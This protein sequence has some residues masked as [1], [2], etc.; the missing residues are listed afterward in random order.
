V[1]LPKQIV[2]PDF[3]DQKK[4]VDSVNRALFGIYN[5]LLS[6]EPD[7]RNQVLTIAGTFQPNGGVNPS[8]VGE[9]LGEWSVTRTGAGFY[10]IKVLDSEAKFLGRSALISKTLTVQSANTGD[11]HA[12]F[13][14]ISSNLDA[15]TIFVDVAGVGVDLIIGVNETISFELNLK[16]NV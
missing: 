3:D 2:I 16:R 8:F 7:L 6:V 14:T 12:Q 1:I 9:K 15:V 4:V 10:V 5:C 11:V 13:T